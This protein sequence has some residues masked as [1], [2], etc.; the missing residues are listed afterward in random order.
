MSISVVEIERPSRYSKQLAGHLG[1]K[2]EVNEV[3]N[4]WRFQI[5]GAVGLVITSGESELTM[6]VTADS[7]ELQERMQFILQKHLLKFAGDLDPVI[8]WN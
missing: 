5:E 7:I 1:H 3:D 8:V 4:G 2:I 6:T